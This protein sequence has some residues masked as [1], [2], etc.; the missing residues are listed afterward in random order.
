MF[1]FNDPS[2]HDY[3]TPLQNLFASQL[4]SPP[5]ASSSDL[6]TNKIEII[7]QNEERKIMHRDVERERRKQMA[8]LLINLRS[9]LPLEFI[10]V[11]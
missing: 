5:A 11:M 9:L 3:Q 1:P 8:S 7:T 4:I 6:N 10:K 2:H